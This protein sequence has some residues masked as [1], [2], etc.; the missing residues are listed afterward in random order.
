MPNRETR[1]ALKAAIDHGDLLGSAGLALET[2][3][4]LLGCDGSEHHLTNDEY[5]GLLHAVR[6]ISGYIKAAG[7]DLYE[8]AELAGALEDDGGVK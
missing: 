7:F 1:R 3:S 2:L 4:D 6:T 8:A 5:S